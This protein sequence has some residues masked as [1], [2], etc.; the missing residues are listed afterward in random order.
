[1]TAQQT[2]IPLETLGATVRT[3]RVHG[4]FL[5]A[6]FRDSG[7]IPHTDEAKANARLFVAAHGLYELAEQVLAL[8]DINTP[9]SLIA[10]ATALMAQ[11]KES[12]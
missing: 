3:K 8:A 6:E 7:G 10:K 11:I 5:V 2:T 1:M 4:G 12:T 9:P